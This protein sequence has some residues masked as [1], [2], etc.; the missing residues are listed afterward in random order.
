MTEA[1]PGVTSLSPDMTR[2]KSGSVGLPHFFTHIRISGPDG[3]PAAP[4][5]V[6]EI[7][8]TGPNVTLGYHAN[9][10]ANAASFTA[11]GWFRSGD[12]GYQDEDGYLF[13]AGREKDMIISGGENIYPAE[14]EALILELPEITAAAVVAAPDERWGEVPWAVVTLRPGAQ[15]PEDAVREHLDGRL[16]RY[17][18]PKRVVIVDELPRTALGKV[19]KVD[20]RR[21]IQDGV[22][23]D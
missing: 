23:G 1:S 18:L 3:A 15:I 7:E 10:V 12:L 21:Q 8:V 14:V 17:K 5:E 9:P 16:A 11:D 2:V 19:R 6:G 4:G 13:I 22:L 20:L